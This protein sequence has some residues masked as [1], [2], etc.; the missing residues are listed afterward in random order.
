MTEPLLRVEGLTKHFP[1]TRGVFS[2]VVG[3]VRAVDGVSFEIAPGETLGLVGESGSGKTTVGR[4]ILRLTQ[5]SSGRIVF[6]NTDVTSAQ[7]KELRRLRRDL[8]VIFQDPF[9]S[10]NPRLRVIDIVGEALEVHGIA[11]GEAVE[12][13]VSALLERVGLSPSW[14]Y[15]YPHEFS[16]GQ[17]QRIG[18]ARALALEPKLIVCD[19]AVSALDVSIQAQVINLLIE[20]RRE[21]GI[22]YLFIAHDLSVVR[23]VS[24]RIAVM[25]L[26]RL[27]ELGPSKRLFEA[28]AHPYT[29]ALLSAIP[30]STP[31]AP[32][33]RLV[34]SGEIPS[35]ANPP[36]GCHFHTRC[37]AVRP[38]CRSDEPPDIVLEPGHSV[39]CVHAV[40]LP[41]GEG[42]H[43]ELSRRIE[44]AT[45]EN[46]AREPPS[47]VVASDVVWRPPALASPMAAASRTATA[48]RERRARGVTLGVV[49]LGIVLVALAHHLVE[50]GRHGRAE[51]EL[52]ELSTEIQEHARLS[53]AL[54][55]RLSE[56][57]WRLYPIFP[58]GIPRDPWGR[59]LVYRMP[60][61]DGRPFDLAST[62]A[63]GVPSADDVRN[64]SV[65]AARR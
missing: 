18:V 20:L 53:G 14:M 61:S 54:P 11:K 3:Q 7:P 5:P 38:E 34:L 40:D 22:S 4:C 43:A 50:R 45:A 56:L 19:E 63:D 51:S 31:G 58:N 16:G 42:W 28:P 64:V 6:G 47:A 13:R 2:R 10:L 9:S 29:R 60:G 36:S 62:G 32:R 1:V 65:R 27:V 59:P 35:P 24:H 33:R 46:A 15:R 52:R 8:Q 12:R 48:G 17:R 44:R 39:R 26:G 23:H 30:V 55:R 21:L 49:A 37:P 57:G 41:P 25:Y